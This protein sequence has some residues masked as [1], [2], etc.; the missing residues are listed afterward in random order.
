MVWFPPTLW[1]VAP[2]ASNTPTCE[3][4]GFGANSAWRERGGGVEDSD[5]E[6]RLDDNSLRSAFL[7]DFRIALK[8]DM[9]DRGQK[10][11]GQ[12]KDC[13]TISHERNICLCTN[14]PRQCLFIF[15]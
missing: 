1:S 13:A 7:E 12:V 8:E 6:P 10:A 5:V 4:M 15:H 9:M 14:G 2:L 11:R 3:I